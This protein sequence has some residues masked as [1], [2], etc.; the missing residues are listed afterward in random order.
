MVFEEF[1]SE[2]GERKIEGWRLTVFMSL[3]EMGA[4]EILKKWHD[5]QSEQ[6][7]KLYCFVLDA[8]GEESCIAEPSNGHK[9]SFATIEYRIKCRQQQE[10]EYAEEC[11]IPALECPE[12]SAKIKRIL[13][14]MRVKG[15][16]QSHWFDRWSVV[17]Q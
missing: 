14:D 16:L 17:A 13:Q 1:I 15:L 9:L 3:V 2:Q 7:Q 6:Q 8:L 4:N 10:P 11:G 12:R 5:R